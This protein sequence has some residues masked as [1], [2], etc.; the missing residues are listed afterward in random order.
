M[1]IHKPKPWHGVREFLKEYAIIVIGVLT[2]LAAEQTVE[3]LH[4]REIVNRGEAA[5]RDNFARFI[6]FQV[7]TEREAPCIAA[8]AAEV[9]AIL[10]AAS[11]TRRL[12]RIGPIPQPMPLPWQVD[13]WEA[14]VASGVAPYLPQ[15]K[16]VLYSRIS[17]SGIDLYGAATHEW[18]EWQALESLAG[19]PRAFSEAEEAQ[20]RDTLAR[21]VGHAA[22]ARFI[23]KNTVT[24]IDSTQL[25]R[26]KVLDAAIERGGHLPQTMCQPIVVRP[27]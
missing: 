19:P 16:V 8:R 22:L 23:A 14:A 24:R 18:E 27:E 21:A 12:A 17:M 20:A 6:E 9:R 15:D 13:T 5:L 11:K 26:G 2:A 7:A 4:H 1:D 3:A 10:D 25:L